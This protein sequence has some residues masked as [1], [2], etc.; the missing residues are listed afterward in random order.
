[1]RL[2]MTYDSSEFWVVL[3]LSSIFMLL[4]ATPRLSLAGTPELLF[5]TGS[6][7]YL[8]GNWFEA[9][10]N[11]RQ[12]ENLGYH[13]GSLYFNI[14]NAYYKMG[15]IG[16]AILYW[17]KAA[18]LLGDNEDLTANLE[19]ARS[20]LIDKQDEFVKLPVW[21]W[22]DFLLSRFSV[23]F[24]T[25]SGVILCFS[26]FLVLAL[27]RWIWRGSTSRNW[28]G[29]LAWI[30]TVVLVIDLTL[31]IV[32]ARSEKL[33]REGVLIAAEAEVLSAPAEGSGKL[34]FTLHEGAK[35]KV[36][37]SLKDWHEIEIGKNKQGW[38]RS[39]KLGII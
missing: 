7:A 5:D 1:M 3:L 30:L 9:L 18:R 26:L 2:G 37:R 15:E 39:G 34:L 12:I 36:L 32:H 35:V 14:G 29:R 28:F 4:L 31:V 10:N 8:D 23:G 33:R 24:L 11:W 20:R 27:R 25:W 17:E 21:N 38:L 19:V 16:E 6:R 13:S 22:L